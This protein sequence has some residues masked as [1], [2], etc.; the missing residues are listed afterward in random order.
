MGSEM[1]IRDSILENFDSDE[2]V[3]ERAI[4]LL[5][6]DSE[7]DVLLVS[8]DKPDLVGHRYGFG[9]DIPEYVDAV[10]WSSNMAMELMDVVEQRS[11]LNENWIVIIT[12][13]HGGGGL[14]SR[15]HYP[16]YPDDQ[17]SLLLVHGGDVV[18][19]E[20]ENN[21]VVVDVVTTALTH[22]EFDLPEG[23][24]SLMGGRRRLIQTRPLHEFLIVENPTKC[25]YN[26]EV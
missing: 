3:H 20:M 7:L 15:S 18:V 1:C 13:D 21:P 9:L 12:S 8:I 5:E 22:L 2:G 4:E 24:L 14:Y 19:G 11:L 17:N 10:N 23:D 16:S 6:T 26:C 25:R